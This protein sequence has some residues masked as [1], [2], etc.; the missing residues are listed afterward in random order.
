MAKIEK[1]VIKLPEGRLSYAYLATPKPK[2]PKNGKEV[3]PR[4][5]TVVLLDPTNAVQKAAIDALKAEAVR[6]AQAEWGTNVEMKKLVLAFGNGDKKAIDEDGAV[7]PTYEAYRGMVYV[8]TGT[9]DKPL[10]ANRNGHLIDDAAWHF[11]GPAERPVRAGRDR[12]RWP[13][14]DQPGGGVRGV[15]GCAWDDGQRRPVR[16]RQP[17]LRLA[18]VEENQRDR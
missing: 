18:N 15:G 13:A 1:N 7:N 12:V 3:A 16:R 6:I 8:N 10:I 11:R 4:Y 5:E 14:D 17:V 2:P 9:A